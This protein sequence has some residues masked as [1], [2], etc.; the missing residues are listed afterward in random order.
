MYEHT[1]MSNRE[2]KSFGSDE[3]LEGLGTSSRETK[4][5]DNHAVAVAT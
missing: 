2:D 5:F 4:V 3:M 1:I